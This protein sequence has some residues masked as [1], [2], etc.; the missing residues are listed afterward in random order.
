MMQN[1]KVRVLKKH[2]VVS[3]T[4][5]GNHISHAYF[6]LVLDKIKDK[7]TLLVYIKVVV[8]LPKDYFNK[9]DM[10]NESHKLTF[11]RETKDKHIYEYINAFKPNTLLEGLTGIGLIKSV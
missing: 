11:L 3:T 2:K 4:Q 5:I 1:R 6:M 10:P 7:E 9:L 8:G